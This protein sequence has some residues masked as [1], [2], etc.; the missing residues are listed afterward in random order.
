MNPAFA[1]ALA[2]SGFRHRAA[3]D[4]EGMVV[5]RLADGSRHVRLTR[6]EWEAL[7]RE[8]EADRAASRRR[9]FWLQIGLF[10]CI[11]L[12]AMLFGELV[13]FAGL[14]ILVGIFGGP[15]AIYLRHSA[16]VQQAAA[17]IEAKLAGYGE[18][19]RPERDVRREPRW[20]EIAFLILVG[21]P[22]LIGLIGEMG[23]PDTFRGTPL[24]GSGVGAFEIAALILI[25][26]RL[27][28]PRLALWL[29]RPAEAP[30]RPPGHRADEGASAL[31]ARPGPGAGGRPSGS[32][33]G[34]RAVP[35]PPAAAPGK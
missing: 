29:A 7:G 17:R 21:P 9:T 32:G 26:L 13:P 1:D 22:L 4:A 18:A 30:P 20:L 15:I 10:P 31:R 35:P 8:F 12:F 2:T 19:V 16:K 14:M 6:L 11:L 3:L 27:A 33:F 25:A 5:Y 24:M 28:W 34:R 23:G